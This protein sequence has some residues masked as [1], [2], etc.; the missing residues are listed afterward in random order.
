MPTSTSSPTVYPVHIGSP[1][2]LQVQVNANGSIRRMDYRDLRLNLFLG[3]EMEGGPTNVYLR[4]HGIA[5][6]AVP[7]LGPHSPAVFSLDQD[8]VPELTNA[9]PPHNEVLSWPAPDL[10]ESPLVTW[11]DQQDDIIEERSIGIAPSVDS[12]GEAT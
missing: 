7:I 11:N 3:N 12:A 1:S 8:S 2:G 9:S 5:L 10:V 4:R 6:D